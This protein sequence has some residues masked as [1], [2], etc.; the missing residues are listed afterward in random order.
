MKNIFKKVLKFVSSRL[1]YLVIGIFLAVGA[2]YV[3]ATWDAAR[4][5]DSGLLT[6]ANWNEFVTMIENNIGG[7]AERGTDNAALASDYTA[8]RATKID[9][10]DATVSSRLAAAS[11]TAE[12]GTDNAAL[13]SEV[14]GASDAASMSTTLFAGQQYIADNERGGVQ[15]MGKTTASYNGNLGGYEGANAK[16]Q[17]NYPDSHMCSFKEI[18]QAGSTSSYYGWVRYESLRVIDATNVSFDNFYLPVNAYGSEAFDMN[19]YNWKFGVADY[20]G[21]YITD[22]FTLAQG[23]CAGNVNIACCK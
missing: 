15:Y 16:C 11:Y 21:I 2:T 3:Y 1:I 14:G 20:G 8:T 9:N 12:R 19:C 4:T 13:D 5:G 10:L 23:N 17:I 6:E 22:Y 7:E 18:I